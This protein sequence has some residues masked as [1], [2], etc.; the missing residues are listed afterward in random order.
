MEYSEEE[1]LKALRLADK[2]GNSAAVEEFTSLI[3]AQR[4]AAMS[5]E[6]TLSN[7]QDLP[8]YDEQGNYIPEAPRPEQ[9]SPSMME[10]LQGVGETALTLGTGLTSGAVAGAAG[11]GK[12]L[13][14]VVSSGQY[15]T[16][17]GAQ[18][19]Q[20]K[21]EEY[22]QKGT[23]APKTERGQEFVGN[24]GEIA[25]QALPLTGLGSMVA[26]GVPSANV[27]GSQIIASKRGTSPIKPLQD[28]SIAQ[29]QA[30]LEQGGGGLTGYQTGVAGNFRNLVENIGEIGLVSRGYFKNLREKNSEFI[31]QQ[32]RALING[33]DES[34]V[35]TKGEIGKATF[36]IIKDAKQVAGQQLG[37]DLDG[38]KTQ[39][40]TVEVNV[41]PI[42][43][44]LQSYLNAN[45]SEFGSKLDK[46]TLDEVN[47]VIERVKGVAPP[48]PEGSSRL[49]SNALEAKPAS[50][51][52]APVASILD[53]QKK[54]NR[55]V[56]ALGDFNS[57]AYNSVASRE[58]AE[59]NSL[60]KD[61]MIN[62]FNRSG[63]KELSTEYQAANSTYSSIVKSL[64][65]TNTEN[66]L[67]GA[68][69]KQNYKAIGRL[70][71]SASDADQV[72]S[73]MNSIDTAYST[74]KS[75]GKSKGVLKPK[76][77]KAMVRQSYLEN[78]F[79]GA[80]QK[81]GALY[82]TKF[83]K[84]YDSLQNPTTRANV[85]ATLGKDFPQYV[86]LTRALKDSSV[87]QKGGAMSLVLRNQ[88]VGGLLGVSVNAAMRATAA[89]LTPVVL[90]RF[91]SS[92]KAVNKLLKLKSVDLTVP[93]AQ[94]KTLAIINQAIESIDDEDSR[95]EVRKIVN[96]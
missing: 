82:N 17:E 66:L 59:V 27:L 54:I 78:L 49:S 14:D 75:A 38:I 74:L 55:E 18:A 84:L 76:E 29:S 62:Q 31:G 26:A 8:P 41:A 86:A 19:V 73:F 91:V 94:D 15:G 9:P 5:R 95:G 25:Q 1:L 12:G 35:T 23:Y 16:P 37:K 88:E 85:K 34:L 10:N 96:P 21:T 30:L 90:S 71:L 20:A 67:K 40:G 89:I 33:T 3:M 39:Y 87:Q 58:L 36:N 2:R 24:V 28:R 53:F 11:F 56:D 83:I 93:K 61:S 51:Y 64:F 4:K 79:G 81:S 32:M 46:A 72:K 7:A 92:P 80:T 63:L 77:F 45:K 50:S 65:P 22:M 13:Y 42:V 60:I 48:S 68:S 6:E 43:A 69:K 57:P 70:L 52:K 47:S 44:K